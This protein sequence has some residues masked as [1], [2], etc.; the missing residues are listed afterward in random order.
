MTTV[1]QADIDRTLA[2]TRDHIAKVQ[3]HMGRGIGTARPWEPLD[4]LWLCAAG[5]WLGDRER[6]PELHGVRAEDW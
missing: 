4:A 6:A 2:D 1:T 3:A 5:A